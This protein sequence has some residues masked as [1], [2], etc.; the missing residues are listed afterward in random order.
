MSLDD[1]AEE[2]ASDLG[3]D[4]EEVREDLEKLVSYS[5][6]IEEA[7]QSLRRKY[8]GSARGSST[9]TAAD[10][11]D[12]TAESGSVTVTAKVLSAGERSIQR[13][14]ELQTIHEGEL[15]DATGRMIYTDWEEFGLTA[16]DTVTIGNAGVRE[17]MGQLQL[18]LGQSTTVSFEDEDLDVP[19]E[20]GAP[21]ALADLNVGDGA[22]TV[23]VQVVDCET[24]EVSGREGSP[25]P[26]KS[27]VI[28][29]GSTRL[30]FTDWEA[31]AALEQGA[32]VR[33]ENAHV[34][35]YRGLP[36]V[37]LGE[38]S[39]VVA[40]DEPVDVREDAPRV[41]VRE[42]VETGGMIDVEVLGNVLSVRDGSGLIERCP[43]CSRVTQN[44]QCRSH[45]EVDGVDD[46]RVKAILDDG[47]G[48][49]TVVLDRDLTEAVYGGTLEDAL[50]A[51]R[52]AMDRGVVSEAIA[53]RVV[54]KEYRVRG[55]LSV[56][57]YGANLD[58]VAFEENDD[59]PAARAA[60]FLSGV[61]A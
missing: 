9:P 16:G 37:T 49:V 30:Q 41:P 55:S 52:E 15:A 59:D 44:G 28:A 23:H 61:D 32:S 43:E 18:N 38:H 6:P 34:G 42:A 25:K 51:A 31:N 10:I 48:A 58:A 4:K 60:R 53:Q 36:Q 3:V 7:K 29:D 46:L 11:G 24:R 2:L 50:A 1:H 20:V 17:F 5:V 26:I 57:D 39:A 47:T 8:G 22:V 35:E 19:Y 13:E 45:G 56:D 21:R 33:I 12:I 27:G 40:L 54:G 14:G